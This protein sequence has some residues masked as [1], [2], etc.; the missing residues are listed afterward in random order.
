[1][2]FLGGPRIKA[3]S[4]VRRLPPSSVQ[5][6]SGCTSR[7]PPYAILIIG[8]FPPLVISSLPSHLLHPLLLLIPISSTHPPLL[9]LVHRV[10]SLSDWTF[11]QRPPIQRYQS[12]PFLTFGRLSAPRL[13]AVHII[14]QTILCPADHHACTCT[15]LLYASSIPLAFRSLRP[16]AN[17]RSL[18]HRRDACALLIQRPFRGS[19]LSSLLPRGA[20]H[21][22]RPTSWSIGTQQ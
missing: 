21:T 13:D 9:L 17:S 10:G 11:R 3:D 6:L 16:Y 5:V 22:A 20:H 14:A 8:V 4:D 12:L 15:R 18:V 7:A 19:L 1:M 2:L